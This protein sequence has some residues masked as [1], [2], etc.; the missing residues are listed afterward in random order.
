MNFWNPFIRIASRVASRGKKPTGPRLIP[1]PIRLGGLG[2][3]PEGQGRLRA[4]KRKDKLDVMAWGISKKEA[5]ERKI[6]PLR[7]SIHPSDKTFPSE[8]YNVH[9]RKIGPFKIKKESFNDPAAWAPAQIKPSRPLTRVLPRDNIGRRLVAERVTPGGG[10]DRWSVGVGKDG[11]KGHAFS[12]RRE[13]G[14]AIKK[15]KVA[16]AVGAKT[17]AVAAAAAAASQRKKPTT[18]IGTAYRP[19][20]IPKNPKKGRR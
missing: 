17:A 16:T 14:R 7:S 6:L 1:E 4:A 8:Y 10:F 9:K 19:R 18:R 3:K 2:I 12:K 13:V 11:L 15:H 20:R 5:A